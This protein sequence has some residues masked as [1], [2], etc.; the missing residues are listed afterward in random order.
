MTTETQNDPVAELAAA[1]QKRDELTASLPRLRTDAE[2]AVAERAT[3]AALLERRE[4]DALLGNVPESTLKLVRSRHEAAVVADRKAAATVRQTEQDIA[5]L[6]ERI[7]ELAPQAQTARMA[8]YE[9]RHRERVKQLRDA[10]V[11]LRAL[12]DAVHENYREAEAEFPYVPQRHGSGGYSY[13]RPVAAGLTNFSW[14]DLRALPDDAINGGR[15]TAWLKAVEQFLNPQPEPTRVRPR[16][17]PSETTKD[18]L[19]RDGVWVALS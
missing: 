6:D 13:R 19:K 14:H 9:E 16:R 1:T 7:A 8:Y 12:N 11:A 17:N 18:E 3:A 5:R 4:G 10:F 2:Q 15:L